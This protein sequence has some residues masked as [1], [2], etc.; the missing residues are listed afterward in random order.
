MIRKYPKSLK[1]LPIWVLWRLEERNGGKPTKV[2]Y[3]PKYNGRAKSNDSQTWGTFEEA[4][5]TYNS[6]Q[7]YYQGL[8]IGISKE[9][10][11]IFIDI[12]DC[13]ND[14]VFS[15]IAQEALS[16]FSEQY[17]ELS[18]SGSGI[19][20]LALG[21]IPKS[22]KNSQ[23]GVEIY[24]E[25][26]FC[27]LTGNRLLDGEPCLNQ[28]SID[29]FYDKYKLS[30]PEIKRLK[31]PENALVADDDWVISHASEKGK[32]SQLYSG[33]WSTIY[34]SQS[35]A[36]LALCSILAFWCNCNFEQM[37]RIFSS[38]G[39]YR[40]KWE[41]KDYKESTINTAISLCDLTL[42]EYIE[43]E[44]KKEADAYERAICKAWD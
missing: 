6:G 41:R 13:V 30:K 19:H 39:L 2:P 28:D 35:E 21:E 18:Q 24:S 4:R 40:E 34:R 20:I 29:F 38:S 10:N 22:F 17:A 8:G 26:R 23:N 1:Q 37:D 3:S 12:D 33:D 7:G 11:L 44:R 31:R 14:G 5:I 25:K 36:D 43:E 27:S 15:E 42:Q 16:V 9:H 32:F